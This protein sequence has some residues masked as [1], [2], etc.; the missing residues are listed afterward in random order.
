[1]SEILSLAR[2]IDII[3]AVHTS[4]GHNGWAIQTRAS[5]YDH[6]EMKV[7]EYV[8]AWRLLRQSVGKKVAE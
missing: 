7:D 8:A 3:T 6:P 2:A 4:D 1:M 5:I